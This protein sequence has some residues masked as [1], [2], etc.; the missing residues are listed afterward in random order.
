MLDKLYKN[1]AQRVENSFA[2]F[3]EDYEN[4]VSGFK[5]AFE[6]SSLNYK[7]KECPTYTTRLKKFFLKEDAVLQDPA[8]LLL[9]GITFDVF[10]LDG[11]F[12]VSL[13]INNV[14]DLNYN[15]WVARGNLAAQKLESYLDLRDSRFV[16]VDFR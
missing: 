3:W 10:D 7:I 1:H 16:S 6:R 11:V 14:R 2:L 4:L 15:D 5:Q 9:E 12:I 13:D 8:P